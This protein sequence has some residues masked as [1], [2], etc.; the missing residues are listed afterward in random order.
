[1]SK[2]WTYDDLYVKERK[3]KIY[4]NINTMIDIIEDELNTRWEEISHVFTK[5]NS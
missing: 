1:M 3:P 5:V 2:Q 4:D